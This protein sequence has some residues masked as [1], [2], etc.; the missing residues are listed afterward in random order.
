MSN[1]VIVVHYH[2]LWLKGRNRR[3]FLGKLFTALRQGLQGI[4]VEGIEQPG[5]R[6]LVR[7]GAGASLQEATGR[8]ERVLG[9][10]N[11]AVARRV[12]RTIEAICQAAWEEVEPMRFGTFAVRA[13]RS[14]KSFPHPT[15]EIEST[16]GRYLLEHLRAKDR[17][18]RVHLNDPELTCRIEITPGPALVYAR[19]ITGAGGLPANTAGRMACLLSG[20]YDS[21]V[22]AYHMMKRGG[23]LSFVHFYGTGAQPGE[24][25]LHVAAR[26]VGQLVPYQFRAK[27]YRV[28]FEA[29]QREIVRY[30]PEKYRVLLYRR[31]MLRIGELLA[32]RDHALALVTGDS[33]GQVA[34]QTL[35]N[36]VAVETAAQMPVFRPLVGADKMEILA[37]ARKI[38]TY[39]ISSEPFHDCCPVF[40]P[41][42][43]ALCAGPRELDEAE[44]KLEIPALI[45]QGIRGT[46]IERF[47][48]SGG[49][50]EVSAPEPLDSPG[51]RR[52]A[53]A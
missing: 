1:P 26:L 14:D 46:S 7:L 48:Y 52:R 44:S 27:L 50:V 13:Q 21:A 9:I 33:L 39:D 5:D 4:P 43:P 20:G 34:S 28:P 53:I 18:V 51:K 42:A 22:A 2:E 17:E 49:Q 35:R 32:R 24:S 40:L 30:A 29:I 3:F 12:E 31:M 36:L 23:H 45:A 47:V 37:T 41:R 19:K 8:V 6:F 10:A 25:S 15:M 16:V 11:Y 38:G